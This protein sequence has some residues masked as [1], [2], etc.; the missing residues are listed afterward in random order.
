VIDIITLILSE[1]VILRLD[2]Y[3]QAQTAVRW[4]DNLSV[5]L[6][7]VLILLPICLKLQQGG[8]KFAALTLVIHSVWLALCGVFLLVSLAIFSK[9]QDA[10]Y[11]TGDNVDVDLTKALRNVTMTYYVFL[12]LAGLLASANLFFALFRKA[13]I[14]KG[15][16]FLPTHPPHLE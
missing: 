1:C 15:V 14:R 7:I 4:F 8:G 10:L 11:R 13:N 9:V 16:S 3:Q 2:K 12:F 5:F 6:L